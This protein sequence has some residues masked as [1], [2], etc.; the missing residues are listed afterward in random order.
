[1][2]HPIMTIFNAQSSNYSLLLNVLVSTTQAIPFMV[3]MSR[4]HETYV[5][6]LY[7]FFEILHLLAWLGRPAAPARVTLTEVGNVINISNR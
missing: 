7:Q 3:G 4:R 5:K 2:L 6:I 1:M